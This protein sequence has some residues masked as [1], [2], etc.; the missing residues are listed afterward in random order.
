MSNMYGGAGNVS[1]VNTNTANTLPASGNNETKVVGPVTAAA[2]GGAA[3]AAVLCWVL[4]QFAGID[5]PP[6]IEGSLALILALISGYLVPVTRKGN[7]SA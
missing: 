7:Q 5:V 4:A 1:S 3:T 2:G 6:G